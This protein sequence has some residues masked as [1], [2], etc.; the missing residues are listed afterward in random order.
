MPRKPTLPTASAVSLPNNVHSS[1][2]IIARILPLHPRGRKRSVRGGASRSEGAYS[3]WGH[4][5]GVTENLRQYLPANAKDID[6]AC[7]GLVGSLNW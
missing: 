5:V 7:A 4:H 6:Q 1:E 3:N 2:A